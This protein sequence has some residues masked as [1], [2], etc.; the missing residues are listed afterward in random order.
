MTPTA[1][2]VVFTPTAVE[3]IASVTSCVVTPERL[4]LIRDH[5]PPVIIPFETIARYRRPVALQRLLHRARVLRTLVPVGERDWCQPDGQPFFRFFTDPPLVLRLSED[6][7]LGY[8]HT[9]F[10]RLQAV[11]VQGGFS[12][13]DL[14]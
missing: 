11:L 6:R 14:A 9:L 8:G 1:R 13:Y 4:E 12:T 10:A 3:G 5:E 2:S 7:H